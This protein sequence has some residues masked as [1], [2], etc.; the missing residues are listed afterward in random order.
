MMLVAN[1]ANAKRCKKAKKMTEILAHGYSSESTQRELSNEYQHERNQM[2][3]RNLCN[4]VL[5]IGVALAL[6]GLN[7]KRLKILLYIFF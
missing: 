4:P 2:V 1:F 6:E 7:D 3:F 5:W